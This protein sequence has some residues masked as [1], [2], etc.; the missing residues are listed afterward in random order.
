MHRAAK[1]HS[2]PRVVSIGPAR[3]ALSG[4]IQQRQV[5]CKNTAILVMLENCLTLSFQLLRWQTPAGP[6]SLRGPTHGQ[7][8]AEVIVTHPL[9]HRLAHTSSQVGPLNRLAQRPRSSRAAL[10]L[11]RPTHV[12]NNGRHVSRNDAE[13]LA[14]LAANRGAAAVAR[15]DA[16]DPVQSLP[17]IIYTFLE[18]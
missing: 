5:E 6:T 1:R 11:N 18:R 14:A 7:R 16:G 15:L 12:G 9:H 10:A 17:N 4:E 13:R 3:S 2:R 8:A